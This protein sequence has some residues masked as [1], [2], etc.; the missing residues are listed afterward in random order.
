MTNLLACTGRIPF[1]CTLVVAAT[2]LSA[3]G[4]G[5]D[6]G[7]SS[8]VTPTPSPAAPAA[9]PAVA[10]LST[11]STGKTSWNRSTPISLTLKDGTGAL[12]LT[13]LNCTAADPVALTVA[14]NCS[15]VT[16]NRLGDQSITVSSGSLS[17][18]ATIKV[19]PQAQPMGTEG[20][21][22]SYGSGDYNLVT[23]AAGNVF[24]WGSNPSSTLGQGANPVALPTL[25]LPTPV[26]D[27][28]GATVLSGIVASSNGMS[29]A[30]AL[31]ESGEVWSWGRSYSGTL[32]RSGAVNEGL[33]GKVSNAAANG[34]LAG[35]V[36]VS[37][38]AYNATALSHDGTVYSWGEF[39]GQSG[40]IA[41]A[42]PGQVIAVSGSGVLG[43]V[44]QISSGSSWTAALTSEGK[45]VTWGFDSSEGRTGRGAVSSGVLDAGYVVRASDGLPLN[46]IVAISAGYNVG[47]ALTSTG[48]VYAWGNNQY[49]QLG[50]GTQN[51]SVPS[52]NLVKGVGGLGQ[53][54]NIAMVAAG[55]NHA[56]A[57]DSS[58]N[59][60]SW[61]LATAGQ[62]GDGPNHPV[63][64]QSTTPRAVVSE[65]GTAQLSGVVAIA[66][67][68]SH[69]LA[70]TSNGSLLVWG[71]GFQGNLGQ[72]STSTADLYVPTKVKDVSGTAFLSLGP[73]TYFPNLLRRGR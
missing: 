45:V 28:T 48:T 11:T 2:C 31:T 57:M 42:L 13:A 37:V 20:S 70:L 38:G 69:S 50:Q 1:S 14:A 22:S 43:G 26:K 23:N 68:Y 35:I 47:L 19:I 54:S 21:A 67:G 17:A 62:L 39:T 40:P 34:S 24:A 58:G 46:D 64:N 44:V 51:G 9:G 36:A 3:C 10:A 15:S 52:A 65:L 16:G 30:L 41:I 33:P 53:L 4:G 18:T 61:G 49:G 7:S 27:A 59:V 71:D 73:V 66:A 60:F 25:A 29:N 5:G 6:G 12:V 8:P 63:L 32:G 56:L 55:G 72:G